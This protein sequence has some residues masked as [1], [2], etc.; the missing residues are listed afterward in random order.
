VTK[1]AI[2]EEVMV[3]VRG[4]VVQVNEYPGFTTRYWIAFDYNQSGTP[5]Q[6][7]QVTREDI[8]TAQEE[9]ES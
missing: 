2:N 7:I 6:G 9:K 4:R 1:L 5:T 8:V 3:R